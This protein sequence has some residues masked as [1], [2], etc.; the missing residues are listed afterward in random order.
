M[1]ELSESTVSLS[2]RGTSFS[3]P[4]VLS[5]ESLGSSEPQAVAS[6]L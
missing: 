3:N 5:S 1:S 4:E 2:F 6:L